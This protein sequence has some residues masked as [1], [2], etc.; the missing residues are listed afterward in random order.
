MRYAHVRLA[1][2]WALGQASPDQVAL[3]RF[4]DDPLD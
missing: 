2:S 3:T 4:A 1:Q